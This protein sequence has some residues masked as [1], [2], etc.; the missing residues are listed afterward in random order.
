MAFAQFGTCSIPNNLSK[1]RRL[2]TSSML[3]Y[4]LSRRNWSIFVHITFPA[5][6]VI[7]ISDVVSPAFASTS[8]GISLTALLC[9]CGFSNYCTEHTNMAEWRIW[10]TVVL[11]ISNLITR[12][13]LSDH[14]AKTMARGK[15]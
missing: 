1:G 4:D 14:V 7:R 9:Q 3:T 11:Y 6:N 2:R 12:S 13:S 8:H 5:V 10:V 15:K